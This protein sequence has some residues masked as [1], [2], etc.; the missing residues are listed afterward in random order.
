MKPEEGLQAFLL[1]G[2]LL[3]VCGVVCMATK[4]NAIGILM[5]VELVLNGAN[6]NFVAFSYYNPT[7]RIE[8]QVFAL[9]LVVLDARVR[10]LGHVAGREEVNQHGHKSDH[11]EHDRR[12][13][14][15][16]VAD[17][18]L[19]RAAVVILFGADANELRAI[20][21]KVFLAGQF[22]LV[23]GTLFRFGLFF[24][25]VNAG[26]VRVADAAVFQEPDQSGSTEQE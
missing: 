19:E 20:G 18:Q 7:F 22:V 17:F 9:D 10:F 26:M 5:G 16:A 2:A 12:E 3:F 23:L 8:G 6:V 15:D 4:R 24:M 25:L 1:L 11:R 14:I 21:P 13:V